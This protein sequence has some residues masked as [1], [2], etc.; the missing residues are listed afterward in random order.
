MAQVMKYE[1]SRGREPKDM[2]EVAPNHPGYDV[3]SRDKR[4]GKMRCIEVKSLRGVWDR[5]GVCMTLRQFETGNEEQDKFWLYVVEQAETDE[6]RV[7]P[8]QNP[9][10]LV[11]EFYYDDSWRQLADDESNE[12]G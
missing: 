1:R 7:T 8:I 6:A 2:N 11:N 12:V 9:V 5:R 3:E 10:G 4:S